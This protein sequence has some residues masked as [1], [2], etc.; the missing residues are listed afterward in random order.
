MGPKNV[1]KDSRLN[2]SIQLV[3]RLLWTDGMIF[4]ERNEIYRGGGLGG[5]AGKDG[6]PTTFF[7]YFMMTPLIA[8]VGHRLLWLVKSWWRSC[9]IYCRRVKTK[10]QGI[11]ITRESYR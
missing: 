2:A 11:P 9:G 8:R 10:V 3:V 7:S 4:T 6:E 1:G 5:A